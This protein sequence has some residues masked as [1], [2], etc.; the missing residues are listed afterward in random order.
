MLLVAT[1]PRFEAHEA[2]S[3]H[4]ERPARLRA[5]LEGLYHDDAPDAITPLD[6]RRATRE[7]LERVHDGA[8]L[9]HLE[10]FCRAGGGS[11]D[12]DTG[13]SLTVGAPAAAAVG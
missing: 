1:D 11:L 13:A 4:P 7:E 6:P 8:Y 10:S 12:P 2:G 3:H 5:V 9:D